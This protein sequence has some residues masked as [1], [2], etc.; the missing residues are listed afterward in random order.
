VILT[1][2]DLIMIAIGFGGG[3]CFWKQTLESRRISRMVGR[4]RRR[5]VSMFRETERKDLENA[6]LRDENATLKLN[7]EETRANNRRKQDD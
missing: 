7:L 4:V 6:V 5:I 1:L 2:R 3:V